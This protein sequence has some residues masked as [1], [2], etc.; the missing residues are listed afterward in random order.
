MDERI[1]ARIQ[2]E[3]DKRTKNIQ[4]VLQDETTDANRKYGYVSG[5]SM[6]N[7]LELLI[8]Q[9]YILLEIKNAV[10]LQAG[11]IDRE[12]YDKRMKGD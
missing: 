7:M 2:K 1:K 4:E 8:Q 9:K 12:E 10:D 5:N 11:I 3:M 6:L